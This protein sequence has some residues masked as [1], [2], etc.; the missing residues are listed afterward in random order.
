MDPGQFDK[1]FSQADSIMGLFADILL[2][3]ASF[4]SDK[5]QLVVLDQACGSGVV[6]SHIMSKLSPEAQSSLDLTCADISDAMVSNVTRRINASG[7]P[8]VSAVKADAMDTKFHTAKF[9]H[10]FFNF[11]PQILSNPLAGIRECHR[12]LQPGGTLCLSTWQE[13]PWFRDY[14][15]GIARDPSLPP[16]PS[17]EQ[18]R[19]TFTETPERWDNVEDV[20]AHLEECGFHDVKLQVVENTTKMEV[21]EVEAMLPFSLD[22]MIEK[23][24]KKEGL[25]QVKGPARRA[26][27]DYVKEKYSSGPVV[28]KWIG[29]VASGRKD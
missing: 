5:T 29:I 21:A 16:F 3:H 7:W 11:G 15:A 13:V 14:R 24:W 23:F 22:M 20:R 8:N 19:H 10:I 18:L 2:Q 27:L 1:M 28:W 17:D 6:S 12:I 4:P 25:E 9:T 26:V